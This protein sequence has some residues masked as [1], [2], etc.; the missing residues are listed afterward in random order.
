M[1]LRLQVMSNEADGIETMRDLA[2]RSKSD[3]LLEPAKVSEILWSEYHEERGA[4]QTFAQI[5]GQIDVTALEYN[6]AGS[7]IAAGLCGLFAKLRS[8]ARAKNKP[9]DPATLIVIQ[10]SHS[11]VE[12]DIAT[13]TEGEIA[14]KIVR[15][16][17]ESAAE[18]R[19]PP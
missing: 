10:A 19:H 8:R 2:S 15:I 5:L 16:L 13:E 14:G 1:N 4:L 12:I 6:V 18:Q 11:T 9:K 7:L 17:V 3:V